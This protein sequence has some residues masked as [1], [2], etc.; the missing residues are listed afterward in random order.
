MAILSKI[1]YYDRTYEQ[2]KTDSYGLNNATQKDKNG[3]TET[4][5][6]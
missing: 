3:N 2:F 1:V 6:L 4:L 5:S